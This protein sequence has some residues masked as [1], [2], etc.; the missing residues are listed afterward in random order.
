MY[1][2][3]LL[4]YR[5]TAFPPSHSSTSLFSGNQSREGALGTA[6][7][8]GGDNRFGG[9]LQAPQASMGLTSIL[10]PLRKNLLNHDSLFRLV[11]PE[12]FGA[13]RVLMPF[14]TE[15]LCFIRPGASPAKGDLLQNPSS[16]PCCI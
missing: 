14:Q 6:G 3:S 4:S 10:W 2:L 1:H 8:S 12:V 7:T 13:H 5:L 15:P 11:E 16:K 9:A